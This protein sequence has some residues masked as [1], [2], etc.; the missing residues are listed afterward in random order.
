MSKSIYGFT[1]SQRG[2]Y[3][4][5]FIIQKKVN[6]EWTNHKTYGGKCGMGKSD[7]VHFYEINGVE[8]GDEVRA[9][10]QVVAGKDQ[11]S[12]SFTYLPKGVPTEEGIK[13]VKPDK[14]DGPVTDLVAHCIATGGTQ[15]SHLSVTIKD[16]KGNEVEA[17]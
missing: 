15:T 11:K 7:E 13:P 1:F 17:E 10:L 14:Y 8:P 3:M 9:K 16:S 4:A 12:D 5:K 6:G 2:V